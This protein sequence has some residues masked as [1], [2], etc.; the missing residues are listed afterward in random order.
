[1]T[2]RPTIHARDQHRAFQR[3]PEHLEI[4]DVEAPAEPGRARRQLACDRRVAL[5]MGDVALVE[6]EPAVLRTRLERIEQS[7]RAPQPLTGAR[8]PWKSSWW[9]A[10]QIAISAAAAGS[11]RCR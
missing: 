5:R 7:V 2:S 1:M 10:S 9:A 3:E 4:R 11:P 6:G 8:A